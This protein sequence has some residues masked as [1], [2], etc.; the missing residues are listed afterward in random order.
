VIREKLEGIIDDYLAEG[1]VDFPIPEEYLMEVTPTPGPGTPSGAAATSVPPASP[2]SALQPIAMAYF[3]EVGCRECDRVTYD[4]NY[5]KSIYP[6]L[7]ADV[8]DLGEHAAL[9]EWLCEQYGVPPAK[10]LTTPI[11]F[12]GD[13]Y[14]LGEDATLKN[15]EALIQR[16][17]QTGAEAK[18]RDW[19]P[20]E[21][22][23]ARNQIVERFRSMGVLTVALAALVDGLNPCA[24]ATL[25][26]FISYLALTGRKGREVL[27]VG[28]A[29][30]LGVFLTYLLVGLGL[31]KFLAALPF[32][33]AIG[34]WIY[35]GTAVL[36]LVLAGLSLA[37]YFKARQGRAEEMSLRLPLRLRRWINRVIRE[38]MGTG[39]IVVTSLVSGFVVSLIELACTGQVYLPTIVFVLSVPEMRSQALAYLVLYNLIFVLPLVVVFVLAYFGTSSEKFTIFLNRHTAT[40]KL[41]TAGL[42][43]LL[44]A[45]L[46]LYVL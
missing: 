18:W 22:A 4:I 36:C 7:E 17:A 42:F 44:A 46:L 37:D 9:N 45:G 41:A 38:S 8:L 10:H 27:L 30:A 16:Y 34:K 43:V 1:G 13:D 39:T 29:F 19:D 6:Q 40:I 32:L 25:I 11:V 12:I 15:M 21:E 33:K 20:Q 35:G 5:L 23:Q 26:L 28:L 2:T 24:F 3:D 31:L 14:L